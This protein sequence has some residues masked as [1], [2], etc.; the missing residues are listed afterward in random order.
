MDAQQLEGSQYRY[1]ALPSQTSFRVL[2]LLPGGEDSE[3]RYKLHFADWNKPPQYEALSYTWGDPSVK[4][5]TTC[6]GKILGITTNLH[7]GLRH[8]RR[9]DTSRVLWAD[10]VCINQEDDKERGHQV[11]NMRMVYR[12]AT[13]VLV[14]LGK[15]EEGHASVAVNAILEITLKCCNRAG[16]SISNLSTY[17]EFR[18]LVVDYSWRQLGCNDPTSWNSV[19]WFFKRSWFSRLWVMQEVNAGNQVTLI[20]GDI[21]VGWDMVGLAARYI[22]SNRELF[23]SY[24]FWETNIWC[25]ETLRLRF[26]HHWNCLDFL[27]QTR[28]FETTDPR[29]KIYAVLGMP[30][31]LNW[32]HTIHADYEKKEQEVLR[33]FTDIYLNRANLDPLS[34]LQHDDDIPCDIASWAPRW[35]NQRQRNHVLIRLIRNRNPEQTASK[36]FPPSIIRNPSNNIL[37]VSGIRFDVITDCVSID[38]EELF[39][40]RRRIKKNHPVLDFWRSQNAHPTIYPTGEDSMTVYSIV[41]AGGLHCDFHRARERLSSFKANF[42]AYLVRL[43]NMEGQPVPESIQKAAETGDWTQ[44]EWLPR[45]TCWNRV[46]FTTSKGYMGVGPKV[47]KA[48]DVVCVLGGG[49]VPILLRPANGHFQVVGESYVHGI[50]EGEAVQLWRDNELKD[51]EFEIH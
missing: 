48:G 11:N 38:N 28:D 18:S 9:K 6:D 17:D 10:A 37:K 21:E 24:N 20:C 13:K 14:W 29:D 42:S 1:E 50:M 4:I 22:T 44:W 33:G 2:E 3:I 43:L 31:F 34:Y 15:N 35:A 39:N 27:H 23:D 7:D 40:S 46:L 36:G 47:S 32:D 30:S 25:A 12:N 51:E 49:T 16:I 45:D 41:L 8:L 5:S 19:L 26:F